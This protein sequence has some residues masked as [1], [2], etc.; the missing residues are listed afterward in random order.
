MRRTV[1][2]YN[3]SCAAFAAFCS[4]NPEW[5][6]YH[7]DERP[8]LYAAIESRCSYAESCWRLYVARGIAL[9]HR[10]HVSMFVWPEYVV[11]GVAIHAVQPREQVAGPAEENHA[12]D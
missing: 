8:Y 5:G 2:E 12:N 7:A 11:I 1:E 4:S 10:G 3:A 9:E 6:L